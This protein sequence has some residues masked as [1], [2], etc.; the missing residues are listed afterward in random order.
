MKDKDKYNTYMNSYMKARYEQRRKNAVAKLGGCC[1]ECGSKEN[2]EFDHKKRKTKTKTIARLSSYSKQKFE[3]E[4]EKC[5]LL[6]F[7]CHL[8]KTQKEIRNS[9]NCLGIDYISCRDMVE[10]TGISM[11][12]VI[13]YTKDGIFDVDSYRKNCIKGG[14]KPKI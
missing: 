1:I 2:L 12:S 14:R 5:Q 4:L 13:K 7:D 8:K 3:E 9:W 11:N 10:K 6:C